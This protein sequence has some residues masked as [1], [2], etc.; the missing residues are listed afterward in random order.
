MIDAEQA[1]P[2]LLTASARFVDLIVASIERFSKPD[3]SLFDLKGG[4]RWD[5]LFGELALFF[6]VVNSAASVTQVETFSSGY[7]AI[8]SVLEKHFPSQP[9]TGDQGGGLSDVS[10]WIL[11][12]ALAVPLAGQLVAQLAR[13]VGV[14]ARFRLLDWASSVLKDVFALRLEAIRDQV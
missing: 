4:K 14:V 10:R 1:L 12:G 2:A 3:Q 5:D 7:G 11:G 8:K 9:K 13:T 6:R